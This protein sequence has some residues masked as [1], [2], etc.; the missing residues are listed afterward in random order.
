MLYAQ[1]PGNAKTATQILEDITFLDNALISPKDVQIRITE[2]RQQIETDPK[3]P[4][5]IKSN[6]GR[7]SKRTRNRNPGYYVN[8]ENSLQSELLEKLNEFSANQIFSSPL[9]SNQVPNPFTIIRRLS[10]W[11]KDHV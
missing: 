4:K 7:P 3:R 2:I 10:E 9:K 8:I 1:G 5:T 11:L 6:S